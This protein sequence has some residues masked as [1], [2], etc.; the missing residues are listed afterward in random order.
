[1]NTKKLLIPLLIAVLLVVYY[2]LGTG[3]LKLRQDNTALASEITDVTQALAEIPASPADLEQRLATA[4]TS[5]DATINEFPGKL[6]TTMIVNN[7]LEL[8]DDGGVKAIPLS[9]QPWAIERYG[10][11][12]FYVFRLNLAAMGTSAQ[13]VCF[14][15]QLENGEMPTLIIEN[16]SVNKESEM[17]VAESISESTTQIEANLDI[18]V[19]C[20]SP[21]TGLEQKDT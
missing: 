14:L 9:T 11:Y 5:L 6:N 8:A 21:T 19:Y 10:D 17:S 13:L 3:Y 20:Q 1:M 18:A 15:T 2:L 4:R 7:I 12:D 16:L